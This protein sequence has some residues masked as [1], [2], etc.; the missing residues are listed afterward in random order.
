MSTKKANAPTLNI[1]LINK[2]EAKNDTFAPREDHF[3]QAVNI[4]NKEVGDLRLQTEL[5]ADCI[6]RQDEQIRAMERGVSITW[7]NGRPDRVI[8][9]STSVLEY[10]KKYMKE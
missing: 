9:D 2:Q 5:Q 8:V 1:N 3:K 7:H 10:A 4:I 6:R